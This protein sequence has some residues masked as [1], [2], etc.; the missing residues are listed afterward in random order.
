MYD[1]TVF[2][3]QADVARQQ[4]MMGIDEG[5]YRQRGV[6]QA[7]R[8]TPQTDQFGGN[9]A[10]AI[11]GAAIGDAS[12]QR[13]LSD[14]EWGLAE[15]DMRARQQGSES[16]ANIQTQQRQTMATRQ[17]GLAEADMAYQAEKSSRQQAIIGSVVGMAGSWLIDGGASKLKGGA[18]SLV[19]TLS[20]NTNTAP[21][22]STEIP[23]MAMSS[24]DLL[25]QLRGSP[26]SM[27]SVGDA[28][29]ERDFSGEGLS[30]FE[31]APVSA[32]AQAPPPSMS[33][34]TVT[35]QIPD[36]EPLGDMGFAPEASPVTDADIQAFQAMVTE[37]YPDITQDE[38]EQLFVEFQQS[39]MPEVNLSGGTGSVSDLFGAYGRA[40]SNF[41]GA[42]PRAIQASGASRQQR[43][44]QEFE[45]FLKNRR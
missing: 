38:Y 6:S 13:G 19:N 20:G 3:P 40:A 9:Q 41:W 14:F 4:A 43:E 8:Q 11:A 21:G 15:A 37:Q 25:G 32:P 39:R 27:N 10:Q 42:I 44:R 5:I 35:P 34:N 1:P 33:G 36:I 23:E 31:K 26:P 30:A 7:F 24:S 29:L 28:N 17:A 2:D 16:L 18:L 12:R 22:F 45:Q